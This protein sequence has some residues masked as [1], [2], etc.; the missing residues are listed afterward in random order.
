VLFLA[1]GQFLQAIGPTAFTPFLRVSD[2]SLQHFYA[3]L[4]TLSAVGDKGAMPMSDFWCLL[5]VIAFFGLSFA[6]IRGLERLRK[7]D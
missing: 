1:A 5:M 4:V 6:M 2:P 7:K 3:P